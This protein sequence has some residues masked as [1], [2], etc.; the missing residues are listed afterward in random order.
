M[1]KTANGDIIGNVPDE[2]VPRTVLRIVDVERQTGLAR[3]TIYYFIKRGMF[4]RPIP[5]GL[6]SVGWL[7]EDINQ[8][9]RDKIAKRAAKAGEAA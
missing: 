5:L 6:K 2:G 7:Q 9:V 8:W 3:A 4:P 1:L